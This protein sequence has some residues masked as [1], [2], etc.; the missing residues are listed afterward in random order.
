MINIHGKGVSETRFEEQLL[1]EDATGN[2]PF[3]QPGDSGALIVSDDGNLRPRGLLVSG[4]TNGYEFVANKIDEV[5]SA[6][7]ISTI[8]Q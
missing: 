3:A 6:M 5:M 2:P 1:L 7:N 8:V 4:S